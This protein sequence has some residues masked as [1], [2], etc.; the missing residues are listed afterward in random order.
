MSGKP[1]RGR[2]SLIAAALPCAVAAVIV[3]IVIPLVATD[4]FRGANPRGSSIAF[5]ISAVLH[6][7]LGILA[8]RSRRSSGAVS[9]W[10]GV[11]ASILGLILLDPAFDFGVHPGMRVADVA[12]FVCAISDFAAAILVFLMA[13]RRSRAMGKPVRLFE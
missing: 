4:T 11:L 3:V 6:T 12:M 10:I 1:G 5:S 2:W 13:F 8:L 9:V 7:L